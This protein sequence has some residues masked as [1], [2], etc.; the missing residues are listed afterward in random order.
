MFHLIC[1]SSL[2]TYSHC[3]GDF[4]MICI[5]I[6]IFPCME[7]MGF[8][9]VYLYIKPY[10]RIVKRGVIKITQRYS[11]PIS[12]FNEYIFQLEYLFTLHTKIYVHDLFNWLHTPLVGYTAYCLRSTEDRAENRS[13]D[14]VWWFANI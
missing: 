1:C 10:V 3:L 6:Y 7:L 5:Y 2:L 4:C 9:D 13:E 11:L 8:S 12:V 14:W